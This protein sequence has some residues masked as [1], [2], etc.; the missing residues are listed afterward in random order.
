[1]SRCISSPAPAEMVP[2][3]VCGIEIPELAGSPETFRT[4]MLNLADGSIRWSHKMCG[5]THAIAV[6][7][8]IADATCG[9]C[10]FPLRAHGLMQGEAGQT[11]VMLC[12]DYG[13]GWVA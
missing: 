13:E 12:P 2:C 6:K 8:R 4:A 3:V 7:Q 1:M 10:D 9:R 11:H 5:V